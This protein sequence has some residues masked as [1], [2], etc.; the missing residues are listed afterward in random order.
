MHLNLTWQHILTKQASIQEEQKSEIHRKSVI[1]T[2][3]TTVIDGK[4][5]HLDARQWWCVHTYA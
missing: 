4:K 1:K 2:K 5:Y 3:E